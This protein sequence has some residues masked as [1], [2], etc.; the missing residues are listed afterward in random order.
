M[1]QAQINHELRERH[2]FGLRGIRNG[3]RPSEFC[4]TH[5]FLGAVGVSSIYLVAI[6]FSNVEYYELLNKI[7]S[8][9]NALFPSLLGFNLGGFALIVGFGNTSLLETMTNPTKGTNQSVFQKLNAIFAFSILLQIGVLTISFLC[10]TIDLLKFST[11]NYLLADVINFSVIAVVLFLAIWA[12]A[13]IPAIVSNIF[14][15]GQMHHF[16]LAR[17]KQNGN[18]SR[19]SENLGQN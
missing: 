14:T 3:Y 6:C 10:S 2:E 13:M 7:L 5:P 16:Y 18:A 12:I 11:S 17:K 8:L 1:Q 9:L 15:F 19:N 4:K